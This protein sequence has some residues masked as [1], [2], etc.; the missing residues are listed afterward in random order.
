MQRAP[1]VG[2]WRVDYDGLSF[3]IIRGSG[4]MVP[5]HQPERALHLFATFLYGEAATAGL[6]PPT[7]EDATCW[8]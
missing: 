1:Q 7:P 2:G 6:A 5:T 8:L 4:H 3:V